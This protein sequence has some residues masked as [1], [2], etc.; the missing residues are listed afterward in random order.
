[1]KRVD[2]CLCHSYT[3]S[4]NAIYSLLIMSD[5]AAIVQPNTILYHVN[6]D[7]SIGHDAVCIFMPCDPM[8][9]HEFTVFTYLYF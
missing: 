3:T 6:T 7:A 8:Y 5:N 2:L 1:M 4:R 9:I